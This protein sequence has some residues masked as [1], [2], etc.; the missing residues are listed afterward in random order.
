[1]VLERKNIVIIGLGAA[2]INLARALE[3]VLPQTHRMVI[4][5]ESD[6]GRSSLLR[7][8]L[9]TELKLT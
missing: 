6:A 9:W 3:K 1:M 8:Y 4:I 2:A 5:T 7:S